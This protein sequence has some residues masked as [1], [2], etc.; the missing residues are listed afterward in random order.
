MPY[1][2]VIKDFFPPDK[3]GGF[4]D[5]AHACACNICGLDMEAVKQ[6]AVAAAVDALK[7]QHGLDAAKPE[8][9]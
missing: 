5:P 2:K 7:A 8:G 6:K 4:I 1:Y 9:E 3:L